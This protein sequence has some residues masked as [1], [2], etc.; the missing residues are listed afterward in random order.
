MLPFG[1]CCNN[2]LFSLF[3]CFYR[4]NALVELKFCAAVHV[5]HGALFGLFRFF[6]S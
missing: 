5:R 3:V 1:L 4:C 6:K 2:F